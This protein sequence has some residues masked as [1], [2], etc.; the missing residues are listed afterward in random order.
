MGGQMGGPMNGMM[1]MQGWGLL[2]MG[3]LAAVL[4]A[5]V[6]MAVRGFNRP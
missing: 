6:V 3:L 5:L 2:W 4:I 1:G